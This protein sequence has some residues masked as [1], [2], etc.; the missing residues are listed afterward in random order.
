MPHLAKALV[1]T[2]EFNAGIPQ[3]YRS[4]DFQPPQHL[5]NKR[6]ERCLNQGF[7]PFHLMV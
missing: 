3:H 5:I 4:V 1:L 2:S 7:E 6:T